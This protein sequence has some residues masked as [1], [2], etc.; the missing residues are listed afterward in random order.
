MEENKP[1]PL[2]IIFFLSKYFTISYLIDV[3]Q[4]DNKRLYNIIN[5]NSKKY[6]M[7]DLIYNSSEIF[8]D[9]DTWI[10]NNFIPLLKQKKFKKLVTNSHKKKD[11]RLFKNRLKKDRKEILRNF[12]RI[13]KQYKFN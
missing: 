9:N 8:S 13:G 1:D 3:E 7:V 5:A 12:K 4:F 6:I 2:E 11:R 10:R